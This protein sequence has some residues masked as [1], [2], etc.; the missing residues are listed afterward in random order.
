MLKDFVGPCHG[1]VPSV[2]A[3]KLDP[4]SRGFKSSALSAPGY[5]SKRIESRILKRNLHSYVHYS[6]IDTSQDVK[7]NT[8]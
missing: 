7:T 2:A 1:H 6:T 4:R 5:L 8:H 3:Q